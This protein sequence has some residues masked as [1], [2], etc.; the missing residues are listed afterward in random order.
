MS[1]LNKG[2]VGLKILYVLAVGAMIPTALVAPNIPKVF[3]PIL[4]EL[5]KKLNARPQSVRR[6]L[7][8]LKRDRLI[9]VGENGEE[10]T[11]VLAEGGKQRIVRGKLDELE[12]KRPK[13]WDKKWRMVLFDV[14]EKHKAAR[15]ALR[16]KLR[17]L[18]FLQIQKSC[19]V[20]PFECR[21]EIDF[22]TE[23]FDVPHHV[24]YVVAESLEGESTFRKHFK[25]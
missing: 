22:V 18:G 6:A 13:K 3:A 19:F 23:C 15:E 8:I 11:F 5:A 1:G 4:R 10:M 16:Q 21:D 17:D 20:H 12:I 2:Q 14:P 25:V 9:S 24:M 7:T